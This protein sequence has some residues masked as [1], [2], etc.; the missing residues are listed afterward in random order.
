MWQSLQLE[1]EGEMEALDRSCSVG[2]LLLLSAPFEI[3]CLSFFS[4]RN[5]KTVF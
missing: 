3:P 5:P 4:L 2:P 1:A